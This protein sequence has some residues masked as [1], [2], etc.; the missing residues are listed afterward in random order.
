LT[1]YCPDN[2][3]VVVCRF[4]IDVLCPPTVEFS[5]LMLDAWLDVVVCSVL[6]LDSAVPTLDVRLLMLVACD[7]VVDCKD[8][9]LEPCVVIRES[10]ESAHAEPVHRYS[11]NPSSESYQRS[12]VTRV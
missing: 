12:F 8:V 2:P 11:R 3:L 4:W 5:V 6:M 9:M 10:A 1:V 7:A